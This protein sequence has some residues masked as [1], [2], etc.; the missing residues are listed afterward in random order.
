[1]KA[2]VELNLSAFTVPTH[3]F[4]VPFGAIPKAPPAPRAPSWEAPPPPEPPEFLKVPLRELDAL[5]L[6]RFCDEFRDS[7]FRNAGKE[8]PPTAA[9]ETYLVRDAIDQLRSVLCDPEGGACVKGASLSDNREIEIALGKLETF[10]G[11]Q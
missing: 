4:V 11:A 9:P 1:M 10:L 5:T 2:Q 7:V 6:D 3:V 8:Q